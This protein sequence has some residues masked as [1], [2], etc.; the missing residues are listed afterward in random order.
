[1]VLAQYFI[2]NVFVKRFY[3]R[4]MYSKN[5][6]SEKLLLRIQ[7]KTL[8]YHYLPSKIYSLILLRRLKKISIKWITNIHYTMFMLQRGLCY[9]RN[10]ILGT[11]WV[12]YKIEYLFWRITRDCLQ[13]YLCYSKTTQQFPIGLV[14]YDKE[15]YQ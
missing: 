5:F 1:M 8:F 3:F 6:L 14:E 12:T 9:K 2:L 4:M 10:I 11:H 15:V 7:Y 13:L